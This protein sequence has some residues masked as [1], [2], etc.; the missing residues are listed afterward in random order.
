MDYEI[1]YAQNGED[2]L[3]A[4]FF[5][6]VS[7]G[8]YVD[9]GANDPFIDSVTKRFY[10][11]GWRGVN[12]EPIRRHHEALTKDR[13]ND[14][15][16]C[17][18]VSNAPGRVQFR[19]YLGDGLSTFSPQMVD[20][21]AGEPGEVTSNY[22]DY[23]VEVRTLRDVL[24][25]A[26]LP[27]INFM[28]VDV[29]GLEYEAL[30][31]ND[32]D[33]FRPEVIC[34]EAN[35]V[36][37]DWRTLLREARYQLEFFDGLNEYWVA[38]EAA[39]R[40]ATFREKYVPVALSRPVVKYPVHLM[41]NKYID[42]IQL[43][44]R[45]LASLEATLRSTRAGNRALVTKLKSAE[46]RA[47]AA[48]ATQVGLRDVANSVDR[49]AEDRLQHWRDASRRARLRRLES[50]AYAG[51]QP[52]E[53]LDG[54]QATDRSVFTNE[55]RSSGLSAVAWRGY[56][57]GKQLARQVARRSSAPGHGAGRRK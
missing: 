12:I 22:W 8:R 7:A 27:Q 24:A 30:E 2:I 1:S 6:G 20:Q 48:E 19:E 14:V 28:K 57:K 9:L 53:L 36:F 49:Y 51:R 33:R 41:M 11:L 45:R 31:G 26:D 25:E 21:R 4:A 54:I 52:A 43:L 34:I 46:R 13:P 17:V 38:E 15:N 29:E 44:E 3:L 18:G 39:H 42:R 50:R 10:D 32:W 5:H 23:E 55:V 37:R 47:E 35:H 16:L 40:T 56:R